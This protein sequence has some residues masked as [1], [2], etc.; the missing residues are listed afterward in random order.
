MSDFNQSARISRRSFI[1]G[2]GIVAAGAAVMGLAGV[3]APVE[4]IVRGIVCE[5]RYDRCGQRG[6]REPSCS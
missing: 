3:R 5:S 6:D 2:A 4:C 1:G